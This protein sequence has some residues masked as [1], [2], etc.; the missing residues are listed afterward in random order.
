MMRRNSSSQHPILDIT[1]WSWYTQEV[2][3]SCSSPLLANGRRQGGCR[4]ALFPSESALYFTSDLHV[5]NISVVH[6][7]REIRF[8]GKKKSHRKFAS[9]LAAKCNLQINHCAFLFIIEDN[10]CCVSRGYWSSS[11]LKMH[12]KDAGLISAKKGKSCLKHLK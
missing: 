3:C 10:C 7:F 8:K 12:F 2:M 9:T 11:I 1:P 4:L 6:D 5:R